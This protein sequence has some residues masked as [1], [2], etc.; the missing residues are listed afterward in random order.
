MGN[1]ICKQQTNKPKLF[2]AGLTVVGLLF[3]FLL[4]AVVTQS[5][6]VATE[7]ENMRTLEDNYDE[8]AGDLESVLAL[9]KQTTSAMS[10]WKN[11]RAKPNT[12]K[13][14]SS[15]VTSNAS[16]TVAVS[17][18]GVARPNKKDSKKGPVTKADIHA[19]K[20]E[21]REKIKARKEAAKTKKQARKTARETRK[22]MTKAERDQRKQDRMNEVESLGRQADAFQEEFVKTQNI[23]LKHELI[24]SKILEITGM[25]PDTSVEDDNEFS[26]LISRLE[27]MTAS[28]QYTL[29]QSKLRCTSLGCE[30]I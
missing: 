16:T 18:V 1:F 30:E 28:D 20:T 21:M 5:N 10:N 7:S 27:Y 25:A 15:S 26:D 6:Q 14:K 4:L 3:L 13:N 8:V 2:N 29:D 11:L 9:Q 22:K 17:S 23:M 12:D 19:H 24:L